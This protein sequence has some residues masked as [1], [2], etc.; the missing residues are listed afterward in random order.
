MYESQIKR[1]TF[2]VASLYW[3]ARRRV[4][5][6]KQALQDNV[7]IILGKGLSQQTSQSHRTSSHS[8]RTS[9][10]SHRNSSQS[11]RTSS[12]SHRNSSQSHRTSSHSYLT[13]NQSRTSS[14]SALRGELRG[15]TSVPVTPVFFFWGGGSEIHLR[16]WPVTRCIILSSI[17]KII[18]IFGGFLGLVFVDFRP[19]SLMADAECLLA[20]KTLL[21][22]AV[23]TEWADFNGSL[24]KPV[25]LLITHS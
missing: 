8:H 7:F 9:S 23:V 5:D 16:M 22:L 4:L 20:R 19:F 25:L 17:R 13:S 10:Q 6:W 3:L 11:H 21:I 15:S 18:I 12:Q 2:F 24:F 1:R 14:H